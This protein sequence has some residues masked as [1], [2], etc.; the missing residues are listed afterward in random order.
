MARRVIFIRI[1]VYAYVVPG[2]KYAGGVEEVFLVHSG[3]GSIVLV[4][5]QTSFGHIMQPQLGMHDIR[6]RIQHQTP[7]RVNVF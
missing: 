3:V 2:T 4:A 1:V 5:M 7:G 6:E